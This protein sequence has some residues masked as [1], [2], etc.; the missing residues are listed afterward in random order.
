MVGFANAKINLGLLITGKRPDGYHE[1]QTV[2][3][4]VSALY[5]V[6]ELMDAEENSFESVGEEIPGLVKDNLCLK[7]LKLLQKDFAIPP[8]KILLLK[9]IPV[10]A[11][12][13]G[14]SS[15]AATVIKLLN[16]KFELGMDEEAMQSYARQLGADCAF[17][18]HNKA[19]YGKGKGDE[20][21]FCALNLTAYR[22]VIVKPSFSISTAE[23][24]RQV[25]VQ[26]PLLQLEEALRYPMSDWEHLVV[27]DFEKF[28]F[29]N[30]PELAQ[31]KSE[32]Y[33]AGALF[34]LMSGSGSTLFAIFENEPELSSL[35]K[36]FQVF[37]LPGG[38][39]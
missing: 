17:F 9:R 33:E 22:L 30:Y 34:A 21:S 8:Q 6:V 14:G 32:L 12:L 20:L 2:F 23:A 13:G 19:S 1:L 27:N 36:R 16:E 38:D 26:K 4:P 5:D 29:P 39:S 25:E 10:G 15:D 24:Y 11:G 28:L 7:A 31:I 18:I 35:K 3:Y 37:S